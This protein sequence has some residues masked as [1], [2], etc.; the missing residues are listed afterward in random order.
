MSDTPFHH[1]RMGHTFYEGTMPSLV[2][3][4]RRLNDNIERMLAIT[5]RDAK[6]EADAPPA[7][8][9]PEERR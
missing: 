8:A 7:S 5:E 6:V 3:E 1:T 9:S 2:R 4:L